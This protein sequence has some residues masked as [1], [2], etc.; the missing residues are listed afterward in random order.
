[1][2][3]SF[4]DIYDDYWVDNKKERKVKYIFGKGKN[5]GD[6]YDENL[7]IINHMDM[8]FIILIMVKQKEI[9]LKVIG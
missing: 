1:M 9:D 6:I 3:Y 7:K 2:I 8:V 4:G 5:D